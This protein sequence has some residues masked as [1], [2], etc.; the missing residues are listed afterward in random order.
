MMKNK[1][2]NRF[3]GA[4]DD[5][6]EYQLSEI[7]KELAFSGI[8]LWYLT[9]LLMFIS[10]IIDTIQNTLSFGTIALLILNM[11]YAILTVIKLRRKQLDDTDCASI[12]EYEEKKKQLKKAMSLA[13]VQWGLFMLV[14]MEYVSPYLSTG[15]INVE[16]WNI[17]IWLLGGV[18]FGLSMYW[19]SKS[20]LQKHF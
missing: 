12:E 5:R 4:M 11:T 7:Y 16:W 9:T 20:K 3:I 10:L 1:V 8:V 2:L 15:E 6:D 18:G 19:F 17:V 14:F 13:G